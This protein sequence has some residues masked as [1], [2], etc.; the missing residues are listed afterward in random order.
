[1]RRLVI[2]RERAVSPIRRVT[3]SQIA[4]ASFLPGRRPHVTHS[5]LGGISYSQL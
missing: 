3:A 5:V 1:M 2:E 4:A